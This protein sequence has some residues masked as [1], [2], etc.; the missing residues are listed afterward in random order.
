M[1]KVYTI[2]AAS[3]ILLMTNSCGSDV[4]TIYGNEDVK[5]YEV[6]VNTINEIELSGNFNVTVHHANTYKVAIDAESNI[7]DAITITEE[8][9]VLHIKHKNNITLLPSGG[10]NVNVYTPS[11]ARI[12][13]AGASSIHFKDEMLSNDNFVFESAGSTSTNLK[14]KANQV[15]VNNAGA[16]DIT[17]TGQ[18]NEIFI[19]SSGAASID[20]GRLI[21][22]DA[23]IAL[24]GAGSGTVYASKNLKAT[25]SGVGSITYLGNPI[26]IDK[27]VNGMG[28]I[29]AD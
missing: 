18:A 5:T 27:K 15:T 3:A 8:N 13:T 25:I 24:S 7:Y 23:T 2:L 16:G 12:K 17:L 19:K 9:G 29:S 21:A 6:A 28:N 4:A 26:N 20:A 1:N 10:I 22:F 14:I 11:I